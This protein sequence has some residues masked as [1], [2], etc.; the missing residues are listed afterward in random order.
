MKFYF[1]GGHMTGNEITE[2]EDSGFHG[3]LFTYDALQGDFFVRIA[4]SMDVSQKI[5]YMVAI[6]PYTISPQ[7]LS[8]ISQSIGEISPNRLQLNI[9][10]GYTKP[11]EE[12]VG[13]ILGEIND[14]SSKPDRS[15]Y[16]VE[17][18]HSMNAMASNGTGQPIPDFYIST[19]N[20]DIFKVATTYDNKMIIPYIDYTRG[21][22][23]APS[24]SGPAGSGE[25][26]D[27]KGHRVMMSIGPIL[28]K[29]QEEINKLSTKKITNDTDYFTYDQF[30]SFIEKIKGEG[31]E[32]LLMF[33]WPTK[34][35]SNILDFVKQYQQEKGLL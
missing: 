9:I 12:V 14:L 29:T 1:F 32:E 4:R 34:E 35:K 24:N 20:K 19:T 10:S 23:I 2:L 15:N 27:I 22:W 18:V 17:F 26:F 21:A 30:S 3:V 13:G 31:V 33:A 8:M 11:H 16:L 28:R 7:Y 5:K 25:S 6:R